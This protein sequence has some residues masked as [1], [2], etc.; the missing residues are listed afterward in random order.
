MKKL[1]AILAL[2]LALCM[3][4]G[5]AMADTDSEDGGESYFDPTRIH[6][7][8]GHEVN[9]LRSRCGAPR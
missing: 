7:V 9:I 1:L 5:V 3:L 6:E 2:L 4:C 8:D